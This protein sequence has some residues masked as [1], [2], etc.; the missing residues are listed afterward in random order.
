MNKDI[1]T[2]VPNLIKWYQQN[3]RPLPFRDHPTPYMTWV[4]E[5]MLQQTRIEAVLPHY[6]AFMKAFPTIKDLANAEE[7]YLLKLWEGLGYYSRARNLQKAA[8]VIVKDYDGILPAD[9]QLLQ[10]L[11]GIGEYTAGAIASIA[12]QLPVPAVDGNVLRVFSRLTDCH[13][14]ILEPSTK[15]KLTEVVSSVLPSDTPGTFNEAVMELGETICLPN[16]TPH[17]EQCAFQKV[18]KAHKQHTEV[19]LPVRIKST[20]RRIEDKTVYLIITDENIPRIL[21][22]KRDSSGLLANLWEFPVDLPVQDFKICHQKDLPDGKHLFSHIQWNL[23]GKY[24]QVKP[25]TV[26]SPFIWVSYEELKSQYALPSAFQTYT[27]LLPELLH[28][29]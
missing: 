13:D 26:D 10:K 15:K 17:C 28:L 27:K 12:Y 23:H 6:E 24:L 11:P 9:Y 8:R 20:K 7:S 19:D 4:S 14:N 18:C 1:Q 21:L 5:I 29:M 25:F 22:H 2:A 3:H 16:T